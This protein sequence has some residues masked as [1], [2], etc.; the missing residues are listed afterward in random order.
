MTEPKWYDLTLS[1]RDTEKHSGWTREQ[2]IKIAEPLC[3][4]FCVGDEVG[5]DGY[6]HLQARV[7]FKIGHEES[8]VKNQFPGAHVS[9]SHERNFN[10]VMKEG[11]YYCSWEKAICK[12]ANIELR[13]WQQ[14]VLQDL[15]VQSEREITAIVDE[16]GNRGKTYFSKYLVATHKA[17][18]CPMPRVTVDNIPPCVFRG[19][20]LYGICIGTHR[21]ESI[22]IRYSAF[23]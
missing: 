20:G 17:V 11:N 1:K 13:P 6:Q 9:G 7:V 10:Y 3:E 21:G 18:Y 12:W 16:R 4:R 8:F 23:R 14:M 2:F 22:R 19:I 15:E 5:E